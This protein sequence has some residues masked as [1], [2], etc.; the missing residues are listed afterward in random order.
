V[1]PRPTVATCVLL[2]CLHMPI[3]TFY[4]KPAS[5]IQQILTLSSHTYFIIVFRGG[6]SSFT[7]VRQISQACTTFNFQSLILICSCDLPMII[8]PVAAWSVG[9]VLPPLVL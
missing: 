6:G 3:N 9:P 2:N 8:G 5:I 4:S 1:L 7:L